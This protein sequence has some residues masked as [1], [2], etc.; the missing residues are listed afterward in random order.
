M[1]FV[2]NFIIRSLKLAL[3][4]CRSENKSFAVA[5][6]TGPLSYC[7]FQKLD[8]LTKNPIKLYFV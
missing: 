4:S 5:V 1:T 3:L 2:S 7:Y 6:V 8:N